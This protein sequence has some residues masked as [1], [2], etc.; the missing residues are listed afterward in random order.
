MKKCTKC[1]KEKED[2][3]FNTDNHSTSTGLYSYCKDCAARKKW[4]NDLHRKYNLTVKQYELMLKS[5][6][7]VCAICSKIQTR[8][9]K[10]KIRRLC[11]DH[12]HKTGKIRGLLCHKCNI[13]LREL[14]DEDW[15]PKAQAYLEKHK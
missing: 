5:Q 8:K 3:E 7:E 15:T 14:E 1:K 11:V 6:N 2:W 4:E 9:R 10:D 12:C 13:R